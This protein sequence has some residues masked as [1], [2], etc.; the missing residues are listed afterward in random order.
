M[1]RYDGIADWYDRDFLGE[2][3][4]PSVAAAVRLLG[5]GPGRLLDIGCGTGAKT[6]EFCDAGWE[7]TGVDVSDDMLRLA[8]GRGLD[9]VH[10]D[11]ATL[12]FDDGTFDAVVSVWTHTDADDFGAVVSE[13][14]R[15]LQLGGPFVYAGA[16]PCFIGPHSRFMYA[17]GVPELHPGYFDEGRYGLEAAG[18][19][20]EEG[21]RA[22]VG[23]AHL[24]LGSFL[25]SFVDAALTLEHFEELELEG[26]PYPFAVALRGRR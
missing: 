2:A 26:R 3:H 15:V 20:S 21:L 16:H 24:T 5:R 7:V 8:R 6:V 22:K 9:V 4:D 14:S 10:A 11:A 25:R 13:I 17:E 19:G 12:P 18:V 23:A 1:A